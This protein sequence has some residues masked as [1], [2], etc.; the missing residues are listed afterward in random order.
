M[1]KFQHSDQFQYLNTL[2]W[3]VGR[4]QVK[5]GADVMAPMKNEYLDI[6]STRGNVGFNGQFT[7]NAVADFLLGY[8][9]QAELSNVHIVNQRRWSMSYFVQDDWRV[10]PRLTLNLGLRYDYMTPSY[11]ADNRMAN[12]DPTTGGLVFAS[13]GSIE[14]RAL[15]TPDR[16]NFAPRI[17]IV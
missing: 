1:P 12:F 9:R 6:P 11:E 13:E 7:G 8:A 4:H 14:D 10:S 15:M 5:F 16:N 3:L 2:S 17:G